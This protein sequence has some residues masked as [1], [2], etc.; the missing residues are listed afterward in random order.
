MSAR[1]GFS[2]YMFVAWSFKT[3]GRLMNKS[4]LHRDIFERHLGGFVG[5]LG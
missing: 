3:E 1:D 2:I 4:G 5:K